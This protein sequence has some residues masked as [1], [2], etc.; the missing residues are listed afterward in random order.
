MVFSIVIFKKTV[1]KNIFRFRKKAILFL[2]LAF[3]RFICYTIVNQIK[4]NRPCKNSIE[5]LFEYFKVR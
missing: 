4:K 1:Q 2:S 3:S 5:G